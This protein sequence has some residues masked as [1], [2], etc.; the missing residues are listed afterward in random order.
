MRQ[1]RYRRS[2]RGSV[3]AEV[4]IVLPVIVVMLLASAWAIGLVVAQIRCTDAARDVAR[5][6]ARGEA[7]GDARR[8][9]LRAAPTG[10]QVEITRT[11]DD[12]T[13]VV[14]HTVTADWPILTG[15]GSVDLDAH[16]TVQVEPGDLDTESSDDGGDG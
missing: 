10:A 16:A 6:V 12:V 8:I 15:V 13:V 7:E 1:P 5:A 2:D 3:T 9:G 4:A 14:R 11:G